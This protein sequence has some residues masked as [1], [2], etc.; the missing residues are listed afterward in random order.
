MTRSLLVELGTEEIPSEFIPQ[1]LASMQ[2]WMV[3]KLNELSLD[4]SRPEIFGTPRRLAI[5]VGGIPGKL[6]DTRET[7]TG[8]PKKIA[9]DDQGKPTQAAFGFAKSVGVD[10]KDITF[11]D[12]P[13]GTY[14]CIT[15]TIPGRPTEE[16]LPSIIEEMIKKIPFQKTM[17]WSNPGVRFARPVHW[18][19][20]LYGA[21]V[22]PV[23]FGNII[24]GNKTKGHRFMAPDFIEVASPTS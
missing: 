11:K 12:T 18:I 14:L 8:P 24:A 13:K 3:L 19:V 7:K 16:I 23:T 17:R 2:E 21:K 15:K 10:I 5:K 1:A 20:A 9:F 22:L 4:H 6:P